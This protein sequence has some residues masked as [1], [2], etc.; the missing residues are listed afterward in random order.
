M[1][2]KSIMN[3]YGAPRYCA[4]GGPDEIHLVPPGGIEPPHTV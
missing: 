4:R 3:P 1:A 2:S